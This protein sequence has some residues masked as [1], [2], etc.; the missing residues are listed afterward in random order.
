MG[1]SCNVSKRNEIE[2]SNVIKFKNP[3]KPQPVEVKQDK[4]KVVLDSKF[5]DFPEYEGKYKTYP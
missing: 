3:N 4:P 2:Q 5:K 1:S